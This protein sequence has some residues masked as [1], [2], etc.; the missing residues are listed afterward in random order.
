M[1]RILGSMVKHDCRLKE[2][3][4]AGDNPRVSLGKKSVVDCINDEYIEWLKNDLKKL[5]SGIVTARA[6]SICLDELCLKAHNLRG[7]GG[8]FGLP[9]VSQLGAALCKVTVSQDNVLSREGEVLAR[10]L[11][12]VL[13]MVVEKGVSSAD[14][15]SSTRA[16]GTVLQRVY[17]VYGNF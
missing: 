13:K 4:R 2:A 14:D 8:S 9:L 5:I 7:Q 6:S 15:T 11:I 1:G 17:L 3:R 16:V 12:S 10:R